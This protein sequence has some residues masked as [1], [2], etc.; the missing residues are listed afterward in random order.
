MLSDP[1]DTYIWESKIK[2]GKELLKTAE[3]GLHVGNM[4]YP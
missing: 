1:L 3:Q 4:K 2:K